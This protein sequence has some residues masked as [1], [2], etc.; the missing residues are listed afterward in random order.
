VE[1][2]GDDQSTQHKKTIS[3]PAEH[4]SIDSSHQGI[5]SHPQQSC[6]THSTEEGTHQALLLTAIIQMC[7]WNEYIYSQLLCIVGLK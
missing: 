6:V 2:A 7:N 1:T 4:C 5:N 3:E